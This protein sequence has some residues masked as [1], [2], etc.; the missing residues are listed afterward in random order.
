MVEVLLQEGSTQAALEVI[1]ETP[2]AEQGAYYI[3]LE[4]ARVEVAK[5]D[6]L[7]AEQDLTELARRFPNEPAA[8]A[9]LGAFSALHQNWKQALASFE[10]ALNLDP[11]NPIALEGLAQ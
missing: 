1:K 2:P 6:N 10:H 8:F 4:K 7:A 3:R 11:H 5:G 9:T